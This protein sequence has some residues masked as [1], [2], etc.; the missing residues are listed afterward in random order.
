LSRN[1][2]SKAVT[3]ALQGRGYPAVTAGMVTM[4]FRS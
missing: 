4:I 3:E 1:Q 2:R